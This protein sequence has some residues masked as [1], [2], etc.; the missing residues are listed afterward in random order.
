M[1]SAGGGGVGREGCEDG[2]VSK[3]GS[4][5]CGGGVY[6]SRNLSGIESDL[7]RW[8][9]A[10]GVLTHCVGY[11]GL[12]VKVWTMV[13]GNGGRVFVLVGKACVE[14]V[15]LRC[16]LI[17]GMWNATRFGAMVKGDGKIL[18]MWME[19]VIRARLRS[20]RRSL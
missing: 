11:G 2:L 8:C 7:V 5:L 1:W 19:G 18:F 16:E 15:C 10:K 20:Q 17:D 4:H 12:C 14:S 9:H 13:I 6:L 3:K